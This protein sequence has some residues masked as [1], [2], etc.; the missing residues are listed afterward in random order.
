MLADVAQI[1]EM[2]V[3]DSHLH[4]LTR[5]R[6]PLNRI[7]RVS[8]REIIDLTESPTFQ[9]A[10]SASCAGSLQIVE[11]GDFIVSAPTVMMGQVGIALVNAR[12]IAV[13]VCVGAIVIVVGRIV[14]PIL[15]PALIL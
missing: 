11:G 4:A 6:P 5:L 9:L 13:R 15:I 10:H 7:A 8:A 12:T 1:V 3:G 2:A 14:Q